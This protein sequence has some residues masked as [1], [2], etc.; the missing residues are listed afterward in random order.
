MS[1]INKNVGGVDLVLLLLPICASEAEYSAVRRCRLLD[2]IIIFSLTQRIHS[3]KRLALRS[4]RL[5]SLFFFCHILNPRIW[6]SV[7]HGRRVS[8]YSVCTSTQ[9]CSRVLKLVPLPVWDLETSSI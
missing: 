4:V 8:L 5:G 3:H 6:I 7:V 9:D 1:I 2:T